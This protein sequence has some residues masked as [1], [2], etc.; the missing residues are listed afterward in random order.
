M[1][2]FLTTLE[3][4]KI[5]AV[6]QKPDQPTIFLKRLDDY[7]IVREFSLN[8]IYAGQVPEIKTTFSQED[9]DFLSDLL[10]DPSMVLRL[11]VMLAQGGLE[12]VLLDMSD[13]DGRETRT[14]FFSKTFDE[15]GFPLAYAFNHEVKE[16][17]R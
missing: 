15:H 7:G 9:A 6:Y 11:V 1:V 14:P 16:F 3:I 4:N 8:P 2:D 17:E 13:A 10:N 5:E 12:S